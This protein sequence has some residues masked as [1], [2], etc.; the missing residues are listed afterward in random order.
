M[1]WRALQEL[2]NGPLDYANSG[3]LI[4]A[5]YNAFVANGLVTRRPQHRHQTLA[6]RGARQHRRPTRRGRRCAFTADPLLIV[7]NSVAIA[8]G[9]SARQCEDRF[10]LMESECPVTWTTVTNW[11]AVVPVH[12]GTNL[13]SVTGVDIHGQPDRR[14]HE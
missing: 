1:Y 7:S 9:H 14:R 10:G 5:K 12:L 2:V 4:D 6:Q 13:F 11:T 8:D 3:P